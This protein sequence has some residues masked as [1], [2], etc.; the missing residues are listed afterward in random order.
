MAASPGYSHSDD[1]TD[2]VNGVKANDTLGF[3][4][5]PHD[6]YSHLL[7]DLSGGEGL[8]ES[9]ELI[10]GSSDGVAVTHHAGSSC[11]D[12]ALQSESPV[13]SK[14]TKRAAQRDDDLDS[15]HSLK[16]LCSNTMSS[17]P[18]APPKLVVDVNLSIGSG[19][20]PRL[21]GVEELGLLSLRNAAAAAGADL[22]MWSLLQEGDQLG[23]GFTLCSPTGQQWQ[24]ADYLRDPDTPSL[25]M[26]HALPGH[27]RE[28]LMEAARLFLTNVQPAAGA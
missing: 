9:T 8:Q 3:C 18:P 11:S 6:D 21:V 22:G 2:D 16:R 25:T 4:Q 1:G 13:V 23:G 28:C 20:S 26:L 10:W 27:Q 14:G 7:Q 24:I 12:S 5:D 15:A 17:Q 19:I